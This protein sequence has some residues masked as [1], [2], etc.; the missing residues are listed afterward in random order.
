ML[1]IFYHKVQYEASYDIPYRMID[2][3]DDSR[4][5]STNSTGMK[6]EYMNMNMKYEI[7]ELEHIM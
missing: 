5:D 2:D 1:F 4:Y 6:Y 3:R 7:L